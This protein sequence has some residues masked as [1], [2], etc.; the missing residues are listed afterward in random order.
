MKQVLSANFGTIQRIIQ[1]KI[2]EAIVEKS[3]EEKLLG[4]IL[5]KKLNFNSHFSSLCR[6]ASQKL[7]ALARVSTFMDP[8]KL[9]LQVNSFINAHFS[10][11]PLV[12]MFHDRN[13]NA[14]VNKTHE[15]ALRIVCKD[16][17]ADY[18]ALLRLDN[19]VPIH[20]RNLQYLKIEIYKLKNSLN[21]CFTRELFKSR[22][23]Q[24]NLRNNIL[25]RYQKSAQ[26]HLV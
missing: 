12:W 6:R 21:P 17:H 14:K 22:D 7:H 15:I 23:L 18:E 10:Y 26:R 8:G 2:G 3:S 4:V 20:Q 16:T 5:D 25:L 24:Y 19:A 11:C 9:R 1:I 13:L